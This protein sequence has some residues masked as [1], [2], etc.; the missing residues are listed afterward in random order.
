MGAWAK[1]RWRSRDRCGEPKRSRSL[2]VGIACKE[3]WPL[4]RISCWQPLESSLMWEVRFAVCLSRRRRTV[5]R[6]W[7][8][9]RL[10]R[11]KMLSGR[12]GMCCGLREL[13][14]EVSWER[15]GRPPTRCNWA[16]RRTRLWWTKSQ[17]LCLS[18]ILRSRLMSKC[19]FSKWLVGCWREHRQTVLLIFRMTMVRIKKLG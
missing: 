8:G 6:L 10:R 19:C 12:L 4:M 16:I 5:S 1:L 9:T 7:F 18:T 11:M 13:E 2:H 15:S 14:V 17:S 3:R